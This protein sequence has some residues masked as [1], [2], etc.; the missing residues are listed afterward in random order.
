MIPSSP[1]GK[2]GLAGMKLLAINGR[3]WTMDL[4]HTTLKQAKS[5]GHPIDLLIASADFYKTLRVNYGGGD[6]YPTLERDPG[7]RDLLSQIFA[8]RTFHPK[9]ESKKQ[10]DAE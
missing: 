1:A 4:L 8:P 3:K 5:S 9:A 10:P 2:A 6:R 7:K